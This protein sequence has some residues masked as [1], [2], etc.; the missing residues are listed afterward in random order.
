M[1]VTV[2]DALVV[3]E[4]VAATSVVVN[5]VVV[6]IVLCVATMAVVVIGGRTVRVSD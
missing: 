6:E 4:D 5:V 1:V 3:V 2:Q